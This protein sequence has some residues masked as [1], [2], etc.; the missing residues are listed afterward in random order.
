MKT[1]K[2][3]NEAVKIVRF[4][5]E[6]S[7][8]VDGFLIKLES[9]FSHILENGDANDIKSFMEILV[10]EGLL[11]KLACNKDDVKKILSSPRHTLLKKHSTLLYNALDKSICIGGYRYVIPPPSQTAGH[12]AWGARYR[13]TE[14]TTVIYKK[15]FSRWIRKYLVYFILISILILLLYSAYLATSLTP[16]TI[17]SSRIF[18]IFKLKLHITELLINKFVFSI[19]LFFKI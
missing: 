2:Y 5:Y 7:R 15:S 9:A 3:I 16:L 11:N 4:G 8:S 18:N 6:T 1:P 10:K 12:M 13:D 19:Y 17:A 14:T